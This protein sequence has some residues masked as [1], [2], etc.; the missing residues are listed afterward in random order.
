MSTFVEQIGT[1]LNVSRGGDADDGEDA[2][3]EPG[4]TARA[5]LHECPDCDEV[6]LSE[7]SR[8]CSACGGTTVPIDTQG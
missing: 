3:S 4:D 6:Y 7:G 1:L 8:R 5:L 2:S